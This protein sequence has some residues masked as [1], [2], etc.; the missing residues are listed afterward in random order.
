[1][2][3]MI[4]AIVMAFVMMFSANAT[5]EPV[6]DEFKMIDVIENYYPHLKTYFAEG[7]IKVASLTEETLADGRTEYNIRY[8]YVN[9]LLNEDELDSLLRSEYPNIYRMMK[10]GVVKD[11]SAIKFV[12]QQTGE[13][14][15][16]VSYNRNTRRGHTNR[17]IPFRGRQW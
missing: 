8:K 7:V 15:T 17:I 16:K 5:R 12:D 3:K 1:M 11:V 10:F 4:L 6:T 2:K 13:I 14:Q 9:N